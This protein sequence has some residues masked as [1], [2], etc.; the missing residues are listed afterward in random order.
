[1]K[2]VSNPRCHITDF[3]TVTLTKHKVS[4]Y[5]LGIESIYFTKSFTVNVHLQ[6]YKI[7]KYTI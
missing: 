5:R 6:I 1:M 3:Q 4:R 7:S 2:P